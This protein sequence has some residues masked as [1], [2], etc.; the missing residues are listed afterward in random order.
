MADSAQQAWLDTLDP[1]VRLEAEAEI[2]F[3]DNEDLWDSE[4][5]VDEDWKPDPEGGLNLLVGFDAEE[6]RLIFEAFDCQTDFASLMKGMLL[7][8]VRTG[9]SNGVSLERL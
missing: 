6:L 5:V 8:R 2:A 9:L 1:E 4:V 3:Y 7:E